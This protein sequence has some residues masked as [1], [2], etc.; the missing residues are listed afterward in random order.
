M[1]T[2]IGRPI[3]LLRSDVR[4]SPI[5]N[6]VCEL[7][8]AVQLPRQ[9]LHRYP[10][11]LSGGQKQR[12]ALARAFAARPSVLLCD[13][14]TASLDVSVQATIVELL[15]DLA[16]RFGTAV[17]FVSHDLGIVRAVA[18]SAIV[19][20]LGEVCEEGSIHELFSEPK[21]DYTKELLGRCPRSSASEQP[22]TQLLGQRAGMHSYRSVLAVRGARRLLIVSLIARLPLGMTPLAILLL[23][24]AKTGSFALAGVTVGVASVFGGGFAPV[25][26]A[27][28]DR[29]AQTRVLVPAAIAY[30][31]LLAAL[32]T[33]VESGAPTAIV[34]CVAALAGAFLPPSPR[35][36]GRSGGTS[37][38][39]LRPCRPHT[40]SMP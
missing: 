6:L 29:F 10:D 21:H 26:G 32:V 15:V 2:L 23:V 9:V 36:A 34:V 7:L 19:M 31:T 37:A 5:Q 18:S 4:D 17:V 40:C 16:Q 24:Q 39:T 35:A 28:I 1:L 11:E 8:D 27:L 33:S 12:V 14:V 38:K 20:R 25:Q 22:R 3:K 30:G 13:E